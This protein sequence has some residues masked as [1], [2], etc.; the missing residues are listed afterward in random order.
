MSFFID[1]KFLVEFKTRVN[2][3]AIGT[4]AA[5]SKRSGVEIAA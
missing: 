2:Y 5:Q 4:A 3:R 1:V